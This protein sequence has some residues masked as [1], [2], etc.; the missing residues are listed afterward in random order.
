MVLLGLINAYRLAAA[1]AIDN[2]GVIEK[3]LSDYY[4]FYCDYNK[5]PLIMDAAKKYEL[6][7]I[8][9]SFDL[10]CELTIQFPKS[11]WEGKLPQFIAQA[12]SLRIDQVDPTLLLPH[13]KWELQG[14]W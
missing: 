12:L 7:I 3:E 4:I 2:A 8:K 5:M 1:A 6:T 10:N 9:Q 13:L 11:K 14:T